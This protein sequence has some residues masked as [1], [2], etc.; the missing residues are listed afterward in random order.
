LKAG[1]KI[2]IIKADLDR[3]DG[4]SVFML[5]A[6]NGACSATQQFYP[7]RDGFVNFANQ[8]KNPPENIKSK[9]ILSIG[10]E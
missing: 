9:V 5:Q 4:I 8:F 7:Q 2:M 1:V 3:V 10:G 6:A